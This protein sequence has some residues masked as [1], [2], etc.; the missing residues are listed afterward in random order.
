MTVEQLLHDDPLLQLR[1]LDPQLWHTLFD[2]YWLEL[3]VTFV[4]VHPVFEEF[5]LY[6]EEH[7]E[8][9][10]AAVQEEQLEVQF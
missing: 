6:P 2:L 10:L 1:Q 7:V 8:H 3:H 9:W 4:T 5:M